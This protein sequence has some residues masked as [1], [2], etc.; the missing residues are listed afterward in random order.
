MANQKQHSL[1]GRA[2]FL[3]GLGLQYLLQTLAMVVSTF[4][5][6]F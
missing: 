1:G 6:G 2:A 3:L 4:R 5:I